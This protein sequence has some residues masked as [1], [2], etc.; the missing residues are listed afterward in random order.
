MMLCSRLLGVLIG[1]VAL[2]ACRGAPPADAPPS[3]AGRGGAG[4]AVCPSI[5]IPPHA[6]VAFQPPL[7][8]PG[9]YAI[10]LDV[11]GAA[12]RCELNIT[13]V[14]PSQVSGGA[15]RSPTTQATTT[16]KAAALSGIADSGGVA[17]LAVGGTPAAI[18][19]RLTRE[20]KVLGT[21][22]FK[23]SYAPDS[24]GFVKPRVVLPLAAP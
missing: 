24:C 7:A 1:T 12:E 10:E 22:T 2:C 5:A 19:V 3:A 4:E 18:T 23:P 13:S 11:D 15:V 6:E 17:G 20:G 14:G 9:V 16:C 8:T 21:Q